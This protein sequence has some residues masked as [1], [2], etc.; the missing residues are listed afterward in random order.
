MLHNMML[1]TAYTTMSKP[2]AGNYIYLKLLNIQ[3]FCKSWQEIRRNI[4]WDI[5][6]SLFIVPITTNNI[7]YRW[8]N[9][10]KKPTFSSL[11]IFRGMEIGNMTKRVANSFII[12]DPIKTAGTSNWSSVTVCVSVCVLVRVCV[13]VW[14]EMYSYW[15]IILTYL[16]HYPCECISNN[17]SVRYHSCGAEG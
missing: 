14:G 10:T 8:G 9:T 17:H 6:L 2:V 3:S 5:F 16:L 4:S 11:E 1:Q 15:K 7:P 12:F 13:C